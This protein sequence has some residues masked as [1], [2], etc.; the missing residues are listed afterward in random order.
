MLRKDDMSQGRQL[1]GAYEDVDFEE[2]SGKLIVDPGKAHSAEVIAHVPGPAE[3]DPSRSEHGQRV[4]L[5]LA[6][7]YAMARWRELYARLKGG[8]VPPTA[9]LFPTVDNRGRPTSTAAG[10]D[11]LMDR[12]RRWSLALGFPTEFV[13][14]LT[15]HGFRSGGC[16]DAINSGVMTDHQIRS[17]GRWSS[18]AYEMYIHLH[19]RGIRTSLRDVITEASRTPEERGADEKEK[20]ALFKR[21]LDDAV[22][23]STATS[24]GA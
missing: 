6:P 20:F 17:Q 14:R 10:P 13:E 23:T 18:H 5:W 11:G 2:C 1:F 12:I 24:A 22:P 3:S 21:W 7:G 16:T 8:S 4:D 9:P 15:P 19:A